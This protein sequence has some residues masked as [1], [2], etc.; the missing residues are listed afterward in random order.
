MEFPLTHQRALLVSALA[1][2]L[3]AA[4]GGTA[5]T[6]F[7]FVSG[8]ADMTGGRIEIVAAEAIAVDVSAIEKDPLSLRMPLLDDQPTGNANGV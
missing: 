4:S 1:I 6:P 7:E 3:S 8:P 5:P 2:V